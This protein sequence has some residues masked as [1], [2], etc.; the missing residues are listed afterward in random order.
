MD[1]MYDYRFAY[2]Y[3][4]LH[5]TE[6][7][8]QFIVAHYTYN[9]GFKNMRIWFTYIIFYEQIISTNIKSLKISVSDTKFL[10]YA[11]M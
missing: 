6:G 10:K 9:L 11:Q 7:N 2:T 5:E 8:I 3:F 4:F 1:W